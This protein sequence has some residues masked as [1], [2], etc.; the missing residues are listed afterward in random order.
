MLIFILPL[1]KRTTR[2]KTLKQFFVRDKGATATSP[3]ES[4]ECSRWCKVEGRA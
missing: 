2:D 4:R 1:Y 3:L